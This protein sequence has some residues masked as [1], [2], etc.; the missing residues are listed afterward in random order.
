MP[1]QTDQ[2]I[3]DRFSSHLKK[4]LN[5][6]YQSAWT[7]GHALIETEHLLWGLSVQ[8]GC[9]ASEILKKFNITAELIEEQLLK[10][11]PQTLTQTGNL[12]SIPEPSAEIFGS[13]S[14]SLDPGWYALIFGSG[15]FGATG[16]GAMPRALALR[17]AGL[18][19]GG[20]QCVAVLVGRYLLQHGGD[21]LG[22]RRVDVDGDGPARG[23]VRND[24]Q[25]RAFHR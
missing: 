14:L 9:I 11:L 13:L 3:L 1:S 6:A 17:T 23:R 8:K 12:F 15:L 18:N 19:R 4:S 20:E 21:H 16:D 7:R 2:S 22:R 25:R 10:N 24:G 5:Q